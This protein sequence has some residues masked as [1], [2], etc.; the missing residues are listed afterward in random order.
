[1]MVL[2]VTDLMVLDVPMTVAYMIAK[3]FVV[4][5]VQCITFDILT[6]DVQEIA[7]IV[8]AA[9]LF[10]LHLPTQLIPGMLG[11]NLEVFVLQ[12]FHCAAAVTINFVNTFVTAKVVMS[13]NGGWL[14]HV[15]KAVCVKQ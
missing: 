5:T 4:E 15:R 9:F 11:R 2:M 3:W 6:H 12:P 14:R 1:M 13:I 10:A 7:V 8:L